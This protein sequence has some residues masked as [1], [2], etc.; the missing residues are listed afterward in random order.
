MM[1]LPEGRAI[2]Y[3]MYPHEGLLRVSEALES[4][5]V[6]MS[7]RIERSLRARTDSGEASYWSIISSRLAPMSLIFSTCEP[8][9]KMEQMHKQ[10]E[11][12]AW[13]PIYL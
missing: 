12:Y 4:R 9:S 11:T 13:L 3:N 7:R 6:R 10:S 2:P 8:F 1:V 5:R